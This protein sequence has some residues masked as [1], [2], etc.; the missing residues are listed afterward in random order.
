MCSKRIAE[1]GPEIG[2][3]VE[4]AKTHVVLTRR[5]PARLNMMLRFPRQAMTGWHLLDG[6]GRLRGLAVLNV[7][8]TDQ[9]RTRTGKIVDC[10]LDDVDVAF[11]Q[12][13]I[14]SLT[15]E[16]KRQ[17]ADVAIGYGSTPWASEAFRQS[18]L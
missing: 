7:V 12:A 5:S 11:W 9:G 15:Q 4:K 17:G 3:I 18:G 14:L 10:L 16:L 1:F 2:P 13:A 8:P 6:A